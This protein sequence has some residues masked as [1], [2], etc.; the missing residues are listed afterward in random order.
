MVFGWVLYMN[1][2][3]ESLFVLPFIYCS[4]KWC[5]AKLDLKLWPW[6]IQDSSV[7]TNILRFCHWC[8]TIEWLFAV[9]W[10]SDV[11]LHCSNYTLF[12]TLFYSNV[13]IRNL[14]WTLGL[15]TKSIHVRNV[16]KSLYEYTSNIT[17]KIKKIILTIDVIIFK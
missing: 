15:T 3:P 2:L 5:Y 9:E 16:L 6:I 8:N 4:R 17:N 14:I 11:I 13:I 12:S 10:F 7:C 1:L